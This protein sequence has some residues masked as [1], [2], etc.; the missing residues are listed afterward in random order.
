MRAMLRLGLLVFLALAGCALQVGPTAIEARPA[1]DA[2]P[3][4]PTPPSPSTSPSPSEVLPPASPTPQPTPIPPGVIGELELSAVTCPGG[5]V[6]EWSTLH[7]PRFHH[8]TVLRSHATEIAPQYPPI[9]P[10]VDW[11]ATYATDPFITSAVD[12]SLVP[13]PTEW[14]YRAVAYDALDRPVAASPVRQARLDPVI[15]LGALTVSDGSRGTRLGWRSFD[16]EA[17]CFS[18][19]ALVASRSN[20]VPSHVGGSTTLAV[21]STQEASELETDALESG[22]TYFLRL[23]AVRASPLGEFVAAETEVATYTVP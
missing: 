9:A 12:A 5:V 7:D 3:P 20:P 19:Y 2:A 23:Q 1:T 16:G 22:A 11:G 21:I 8:Y 13:G 14:S 6:L 15:E 18:W 17:A 4:S 10:A